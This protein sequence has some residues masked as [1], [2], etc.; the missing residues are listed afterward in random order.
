MEI[1]SADSYIEKT[2]NSFSGFSSNQ[3]MFLIFLLCLLLLT[4]Y[5][6]A[7]I[8]QVLPQTSSTWNVVENYE[9]ISKSSDRSDGE[10]LAFEGEEDDVQNF[11]TD[12]PDELVREIYVIYNGTTVVLSSE[13]VRLMYRE[14]CPYADQ[15]DVDTPCVNTGNVQKYT[16]EYLRDLLDGK[17]EYKIA[18]NKWGSFSY[19]DPGNGPDESKLVSDIVTL[20][21]VRA[22]L[23]RQQILAG[24]EGFVSGSGCYREDV[25]GVADV[26]GEQ[27]TSVDPSAIANDTVYADKVEIAGTEGNYAEKYIEID[28]SQQHLYAWEG[29]E[30]AADY[31]VSGFF[32]E[33]AV[34]GVFSIKNKSPNA[35]SSIAEKW[36]PFWMAYYFDPKQQAWFGIHELVY[37]TDKDGVYHEESS[38]SI[39]NR[40]SG[41]CI[42]L[43]RGEAELLYDWVEVGIPVLIHP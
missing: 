18:A 13:T 37:W 30:L 33:Y 39:G 25:A 42:R 8:Y 35:W 21:S 9:G 2:Q 24:Q 34:Y 40:K 15:Y 3:R 6:T 41:G 17:L 36:M 27:V 1:Y 14:A 28:D 32:E 7:R 12:F 29:G 4:P 26:V 43:D 20:L 19:R 11:S 22:R 10:V 16:S 5:L 38:D 23:Y 31:E